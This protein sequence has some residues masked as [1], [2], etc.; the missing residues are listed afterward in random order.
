M[1]SFFLFLMYSNF[2][3]LS[4]SGCG[5]M[6]QFYF[7]QIK[8][9]PNDKSI[10]S[11]NLSTELNDQERCPVYVHYRKKGSNMCT[12]LNQG[13]RVRHHRPASSIIL[14][15]LMCFLVKERFDL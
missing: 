3:V 1:I 13:K 15:L 7:L 14:S 2:M 11:V 6:S 10:E 4:F 8:K 12:T 9:N 5:C